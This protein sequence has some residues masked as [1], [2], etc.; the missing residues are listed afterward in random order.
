MLVLPLRAAAHRPLRKNHMKKTLLA[1]ALAVTSLTALA[2]QPAMD[3]DTARVLN[4]LKQSYPST[5]FANIEKSPLPGVYEVTMGKNIAYTDKEGRY[6]LFG[7]VY[8]M[9]TRQDLTAPKREALNKI[10]V[11]KLPLAD[12][13]VTKRGN[14]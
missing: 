8:D 5:T 14:G 1:L 13:F 10:D 9:Q 7:S 12:A 2:A 3:P 4:K 11:T 6:F